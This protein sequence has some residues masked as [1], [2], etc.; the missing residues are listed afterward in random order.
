MRKLFT[1]LF[2][3]LSQVLTLT[4]AQFNWK[5]LDE[6]A[7]GLTNYLYAKGDTLF[8]FSN[9]EIYISSNRGDSWNKILS[10]RK[11]SVK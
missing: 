7:G 9:R 2:L 5:P 1:Y 6:P 10:S 4:S 8:T 11:V 3:L